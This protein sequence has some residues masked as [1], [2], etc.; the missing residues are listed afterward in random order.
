GDIVADITKGAWADFEGG[1]ENIDTTP[2]QTGYVQVEDIDG[3]IDET[4]FYWSSTGIIQYQDKYLKFNRFNFTNVINGIELYNHDHLSGSGI[5]LDLVETTVHAITNGVDL[6]WRILSTEQVRLHTSNNVTI[7]GG[8]SG[9]TGDG[10]YMYGNPTGTDIRD[11]DIS[12]GG[13]CGLHIVLSTSLG[14]VPD[15]NISIYDSC[16]NSCSGD[17]VRIEDET[18]LHYQT[19]TSIYLESVRIEDNGGHGLYRREDEGNGSQTAEFTAINSVISGNSSNGIYLHGEDL[20]SGFAGHGARF[21]V[22]LLNVT[23]TDNGEDGLKLFS[24]HTAGANTITTTNTI[25]ANNGGDG[26]DA[27]DNLADTA[28][29]TITEDYNDFFVNTGDDIK[30]TGTGGVTTPALG[31]NDLTIDPDLQGGTDD[32]Y[33]PVVNN[34]VLVGG[35]ASIYPAVDILGTARPDGAAPSMGAYETAVPLSTGTLFKFM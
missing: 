24:E 6:R 8:Q 20:Y 9:G 14:W 2:T 5:H 13:G 32:P 28:G 3:T 16:F 18:M 33:R 4:G 21:D 1:W 12:S 22:S 7:Y 34:A 27:E 25:I 29:P 17:G 11:A 15:L 31:A 30:R 35:N 23:L 19:P 10:V 26:I